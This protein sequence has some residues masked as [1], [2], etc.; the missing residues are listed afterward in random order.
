[1]S[2]P[3]EWCSPLWR[4]FSRFP[5]GWAGIALLILRLVVGAS[6]AVEATFFLAGLH[7]PVVL[8]LAAAATLAGAAL[9][10][11]FMTPVASILIAALGLAL[12]FGA[13]VTALRLFDSRMALF[14]FIVI[15]TA[16]TILGPGSTSI[17]A[18]L[19]GLREVS[20]SDKK[21]PEDT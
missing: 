15:A 5:S 17:D 8:V 14:E 9:V 21:R 6:A 11:G 1:M 13:D 4:T 16:V 10:L 20:I 3:C 7:E 12:L 2:P 19:F 18:R